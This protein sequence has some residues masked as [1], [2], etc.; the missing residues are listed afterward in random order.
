MAHICRQIP[1]FLSGVKKL[2]IVTSVTP[3]SPHDAADASQWLEV[4]QAFGGVEELHVS[5]GSVPDVARALQHAAR[6][7]P[8]AAEVLPVLREL[9]F[10]WFAARWEEAVASFINARQISGLS[11]ITFHRPK[12]TLV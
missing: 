6:E 9:H 7:S 11:P 12:I 1:P 2:E 10:D 3:Q 4:F 5:Y 8:R